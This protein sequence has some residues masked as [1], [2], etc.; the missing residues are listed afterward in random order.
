MKKIFLALL[1]SL[2]IKLAL[3]ACETKSDSQ[4]QYRFAGKAEGQELLMANTEYYDG[5]TENELQFKMQSKDAT[6]EK[7]RDF[8]RETSL[9]MTRSVPSSTDFETIYQPLQIYDKIYIL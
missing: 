7:Y 6:V 2:C 4:I 5:L 9:C 8:A 3:T 1:A